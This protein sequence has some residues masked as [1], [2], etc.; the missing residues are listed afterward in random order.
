MRDLIMLASAGACGVMPTGDIKDWHKILQLALDHNVLPLVACAIIHAPDSQ[1]P[2]TI[3]D[4]LLDALRMQSSTNLIR[5][6]RIFHLLEAM[7]RVKIEARV[8]KGYSVAQYYA[9]PESRDSVD[10]DIWIQPNQESEALSFLQNEGFQIL[11]RGAACHHSVAQH[12]KFGKIEIHISLYDEIVEDVWFQGM[13]GAEYVQESYDTIQF[14]EGRLIT[15]GP[16]DQLIFL[17]LHMIKHFISGGLSIRMMLDTALH[18][19]LNKDSIDN[20][21]YWGIMDKLKYSMLINGI[22][23]LLVSTGVFGRDDF[24]GAQKVEISVEEAILTDMK[25]GGYM[26]SRELQEREISSMEY[27]RRVLRKR[28]NSVQYL[29]YMLKWK[30]KGTWVFLFPS[31]QQL[32][33][34]YSEVARLP[35]LAP[36]FWCYHAINH[37]IHKLRSGVLHKQI[38]SEHSAV[39]ECVK[40]RI[41]LFEQLEML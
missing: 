34:N 4:Y 5:R 33:Q 36:A 21:R 15:L 24:P 40:A 31:Y 28:L 38:R 26:G 8:L 25:R 3:R 29:T 35:I 13:D 30:V 41:E 16:T 23:G 17:S 39:S 7:N 18:F 19:K 9:Y 1:C 12:K 11:E 14:P 6:Q 37:L 20:I 10:T 27:N 2:E 22:L 32:K